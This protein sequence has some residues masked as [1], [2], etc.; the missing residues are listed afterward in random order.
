MR[1]WRR[2]E[3]EVE[4]ADEADEEEVAAIAIDNEEEGIDDDQYK[5]M[6]EPM[7]VVDQEH[8][9]AE[10]ISVSAGAIPLPLP[11]SVNDDDDHNDRLDLDS[12]QQMDE[13]EDNGG[14]VAS[15]SGGG[16][17]EQEIKSLATLVAMPLPTDAL[18]FGVPMLAP[19]SVALQCKFRVKLV[20]GPLKKGKAGQA[21]LHELGRQA[22]LS[23][24]GQGPDGTTVTKREADLLKALGDTEIVQCI[25]GNCKIALTSGKK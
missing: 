9:D 19:W 15:G 20:P 7:P 13:N 10:L 11:P 25:A 8:A 12:Y 17:G 1:R 18:M 6:T 23:G 16:G 5:A 4:E 24:A 14:F 22:K 3:T 21:V 2:R